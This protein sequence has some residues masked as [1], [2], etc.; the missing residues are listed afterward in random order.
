MSHI[1][2]IGV[3]GTCC[4]QRHQR[5]SGSWLLGRK[6]RGQKN[7]T[8]HTQVKGDAGTIPDFLSSAD[9]KTEEGPL[10]RLT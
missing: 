1:L 8:A 3:V 9:S 6:P 7:L 5:V 2:K 4:N 10:D